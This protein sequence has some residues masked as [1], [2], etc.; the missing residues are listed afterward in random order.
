MVLAWILFGCYKTVCIATMATAIFMN[1][2]YWNYPSLYLK[3]DQAPGALSSNQRTQ[4]C[5]M[6]L[7]TLLQWDPAGKKHPCFC[8]LMT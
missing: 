1:S 6:G 5:P 8:V 3:G 2:A 7:E 4:L